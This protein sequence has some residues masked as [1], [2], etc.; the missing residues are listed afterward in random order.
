MARW[1]WPRSSK[2]TSSFRRAECISERL[3]SSATCGP[4]FG[5]IIRASVAFS[6]LFGCTTCSSLPSCQVIRF[7]SELCRCSSLGDFFAAIWSSI[8]RDCA[9]DDV[10]DH[11]REV[12]E[13][14]SSRNQSLQAG[15][16]GCCQ[17]SWRGRA[18]ERP[19][20]RGIILNRRERYGGI[21]LVEGRRGPR[22]SRNDALA[23][24]FEEH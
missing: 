14:R 23:D 7:L 24:A 11:E 17:R 1:P 9:A 8:G 16:G 10:C 22:L 18:T 5:R 21:T 6:D 13:R 3:A 2:N 15:S 20:R 4:T 12:A 19:I